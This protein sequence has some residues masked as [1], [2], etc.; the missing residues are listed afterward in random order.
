[1]KILIFQQ[2][3][4]FNS[5][6]AHGAHVSESDETHKIQQHIQLQVQLY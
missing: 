2:N 5:N 6:I 3:P 1:M 4:K